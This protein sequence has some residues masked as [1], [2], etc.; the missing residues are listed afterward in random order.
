M[1][2]INIF[3]NLVGCLDKRLP[4]SRQQSRRAS[5][6]ETCCVGVSNAVSSEH[7]ELCMLLSSPSHL[8]DRCQACHGFPGARRMR[9]GGTGRD[10]R[11]WVWRESLSFQSDSSAPDTRPHP[12]NLSIGI[13]SWLTKRTA[14][15]Q[16]GPFRDW[17]RGCVL[18]VL[19]QHRCSISMFSDNTMLQR[20]HVAWC[21]CVR[22]LRR[23]L[24]TPSLPEL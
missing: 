20:K 7:V 22:A 13:S 14:Q 12:H 3:Y 24:S 16:T 23:S 21:V 8:T 5:P 18:P 9:C 11:R 10:G 17:G 6:G 15:L 19:E 2:D 4:G 1:S